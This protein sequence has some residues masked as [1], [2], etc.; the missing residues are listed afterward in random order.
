MLLSIGEQPVNTL[1]DSG[2]EEAQIA[3]EILRA[4][5]FDVQCQDW[6][7]N[8][9]RGVVLSPD[10]NNEIQ[11]PA[12]CLKVDTTRRDRHINVVQRGLRLY[13]Q[14]ANTYR[15]DGSVTVDMAIQLPIDELPPAA[16][17]YIVHVAGR[18]FQQSVMASTVIEAFTEAA[19]YAALATL[20]QTD[21]QNAD[22]NVLYDSGGA[23]RTVMRDRR[24]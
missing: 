19:E 15:F 11:L 1:D 20:K 18:R 8:Q 9:N 5:S 13:N 7:F 3:R 10:V 21:L 4:A 2:V 17:S 24:L 12:N 16:Y 23:R 14:D 22:H 6:H